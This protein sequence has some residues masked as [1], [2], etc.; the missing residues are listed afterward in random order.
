MQLKKYSEDS[1]VHLNLDQMPAIAAA[2]PQVGKPMSCIHTWL[3]ISTLINFIVEI[4]ILDK[5]NCILSKRAMRPI[6]MTVQVRLNGISTYQSRQS[7]AAIHDITITGHTRHHC[8][9]PYT[10]SP[11]SAIRAISVSGHKRHLHLR[12][13]VTLPHRPYNISPL[14]PYETHL[15]LRPVCATLPPLAKL[16]GARQTNNKETNDAHCSLRKTLHG[17]VSR[18]RVIL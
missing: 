4:V 6:Y 16:H 14:R 11:S 2:V 10:T 5:L 18:E 1:P 17:S 15:Q 8:L 7:S 12:P 13:H 9:R 3:L